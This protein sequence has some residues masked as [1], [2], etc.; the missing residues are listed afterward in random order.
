MRIIYEGEEEFPLIKR[1]GCSVC[2]AAEPSNYS[3]AGTSWFLLGEDGTV[4][5]GEGCLL[6]AIGREEH[7]SCTCGGAD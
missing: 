3:E 7:L 4:V 1:K 6:V 5:C 2:G